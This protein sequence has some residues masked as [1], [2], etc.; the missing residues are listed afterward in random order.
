MRF[1]RLIAGPLSLL[2]A[3]GPALAD[4]Q[5]VNTGTAASTG[6]GDTLRVSFTKLNANDAELYASIA[7]LQQQLALF[8]GSLTAEIG[9]AQSAEAL[10]APLASPALT[11][12]PTAPTAPAGTGTNQIATTQFVATAV[13][14][15]GG[16][17]GTGGVPTSRQILT[18]GL[19]TGGGDLSADRTIT[20]PKAA[21]SDVATGTDDA[22]ALTSLSVAAALGS[23][24]PL[25]SPALTGTPTAPTAAA[26]T[27]TTQIATTAFVAGAL[28]SY[29]TTSSAASTYAPLASAVQPP[30]GRLT[31]TSGAPVLTS[32]VSAVASVLYTPYSGNLIPLWNGSA[33][34]MTTFAEVSQT[35]AD[36]T[37]SPSAAAA[38]N[39]Y[40][41]FAWSDGG[42]FRVTRGPAWSAGTGGSNTARGTGAGST[43]LS[44]VNGVFVNANTITNGP[45]AGFGTY[46]GT[47]AT[48]SGGATVSYN[49]GSAAAGGGAAS[50]GL[51]NAYNRVLV[52]GQVQDAAASWT[53]ATASWRNADGSAS[54]R[55]TFVTGLAEDA[56]SADYLCATAGS[57][58]GATYIGVALNGA[59]GGATGWMGSQANGITLTAKNRAQALGQNYFQA[60]EYVAGGTSTFLGVSGQTFSGLFWRGRY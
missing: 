21:Q 25:A 36:A 33:F 55:V 28:G 44:R 57:T 8:N 20:V 42:T 19:A 10:K 37:K 38:G 4:Q 35:L 48:D 31:L 2:L 59:I 7:S 49:P 5:P 54:N 40:D 32:T 29:L 60:Q 39:V 47:I 53:Y 17:G 3:L 15:G 50:I 27:N 43:A 51:W 12:V 30:Q 58:G 14:A 22:K 23:K 1:G 9:R 11:G 34:V 52:E 45:A 13:A 16:G 26:S 6:S 46:V 18:S 41:L 24:A 56:W